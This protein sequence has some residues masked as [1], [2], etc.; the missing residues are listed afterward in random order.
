MTIKCI[1]ITMRNEKSHVL[2]QI[3]H[4]FYYYKN[5]LIIINLDSKLFLTIYFFLIL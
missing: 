4:V 1:K 3:V 5:D 2:K